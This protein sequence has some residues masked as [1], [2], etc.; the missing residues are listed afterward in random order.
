MCVGSF[1]FSDVDKSIWRG[2]MEKEE[3]ER[4]QKDEGLLSS[5]WKIMHYFLNSKVSHSKN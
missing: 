1:C 3:C 5:S 2:V 4:M